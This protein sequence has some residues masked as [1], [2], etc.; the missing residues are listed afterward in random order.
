MRY[1]SVQYYSRIRKDELIMAKEKMCSEEN[2]RD[3]GYLCAKVEFYIKTIM[4]SDV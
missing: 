1:S 4:R 2:N 3:M